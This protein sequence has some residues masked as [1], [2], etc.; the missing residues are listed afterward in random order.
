MGKVWVGAGVKEIFKR[1]PRYREAPQDFGTLPEDVW[2][3]CPRC[4][5]LVYSKELEQTLRVCSKCKYHFGVSAR[6][7]VRMTLDADTFVEHDAGMQSADPLHFGSRGEL[8]SAKLEQYAE[9]SGSKE[10]FVYG[11]GKIDGQDV[12]IGV[13]EFGFCGGTMGAV[14]GEKLVRAMEL[15]G[16]RSWPL[17]VVSSGGGARMQ[18]GAVSLLQMAKTVTALDRFKALGLPF[19]SIMVD[20]C[21]GGMTASY[22]MLGDVNIA[23]PGAYIGFAG[24][25]VIEQTMRQ[26]LPQDAATAEFLQQHGMVDMVVARADIPGMLARL[27]R[28]FVTANRALEGRRLVEQHA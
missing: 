5:E 21:L 25:R 22:A 11:E 3:R 1:H 13:T 24:R 23:E 10:A 4:H 7:R 8:Y 27:I 20:P 12:V 14:F 17:V 19:F 2:V 28:M 18:E 9:K 16:R 6:E 15:A 26:K